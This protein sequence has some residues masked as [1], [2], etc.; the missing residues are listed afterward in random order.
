[1][2]KY[3]GVLSLWSPF[4]RQFLSTLSPIRNLSATASVQL[5]HLFLEY[6]RMK[7]V[8]IHTSR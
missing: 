3:K 5:Q 8:K 2:V 7:H 4:I 1:M 6:I